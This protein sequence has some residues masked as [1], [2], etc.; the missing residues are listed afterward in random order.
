MNLREPFTESLDDPPR[1][2]VRIAFWRHTTAGSSDPTI[3]IM[4]RARGQIVHE[5]VNR[6]DVTVHDWGNV[7]ASHPSE[8]VEILVG[9]LVGVAVEKLVNYL[10]SKIKEPQETPGITL[11]AVTFRRDDGVELVWH[12][13]AGVSVQTATSEMHKFMKSL[14]VERI[15]GSN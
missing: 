1:E 8:V 4:H 3:P 7:D 14:P 13:Q 9:A 11:K 5:M 10:W 6:V 12:F 2:Q 15:L